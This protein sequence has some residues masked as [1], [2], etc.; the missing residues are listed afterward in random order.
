MAQKQDNASGIFAVEEQPGE[1]IFALAVCVAAAVLVLQIDDQTKWLEGSSLLVQPRF[2][3]SLCLAGFSIFALCHLLSSVARQARSGKYGFFPWA[4]LSN[5]AQPLEYA[6]YFMG[7][8]F[9]VPQLG[10]L[11]TTLLV[12]P[13]LTL[14]SGYRKGRVLLAAAAV[15][16]CTVLVF[17]SFL[18][19]R[20]PGG[21][22]YELLPDG[23][24]NFLI[25]YF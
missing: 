16:L 7:Y 17:K 12:L 1:A 3:P 20:I 21:Y 18:Q 22:F 19:V 23:L 13:A 14:R 9:L 11:P 2:W 15:G 25:L 6:L 10:Y 8:V 24:R 5:W 4:E